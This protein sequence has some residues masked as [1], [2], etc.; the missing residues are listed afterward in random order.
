MSI[1]RHLF[2]LF[3]AVT[4]AAA[5]VSHA[6]GDLHVLLEQVDAKLAKEPEN[7]QLLLERANLYRQH[8]D[9]SKALEDLKKVETLA[10]KSTELMILKAKVYSGLGEWKMAVES[11]DQFLDEV[12]DSA[13]GYFL[14]S[15][16]NEKLGAHDKAV[17]DAKFAIRNS[18]RPPL[19]Y[20]F[21]YINLLKLH[22]AKKDVDTAFQEAS[23][24]YGQLPT[25]ASAHA[26]WLAENGRPDQASSIYS[27]LR[28]STPNLSFNWWVEEYQLWKEMDSEKALSAKTNALKAWNALPEKIRSR[29]AMQEKHAEFLKISSEK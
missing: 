28:E 15:M 11:F 7:S 12:D 26:L 29:Q 6:H 1:R 4:A 14:R 20:Y 25:F 19:P 10:P 13:E 24:V 2:K 16:A 22:G 9:Y 21:H 5:P 27:D 3:V 17:D 8:E 23:K 18:T